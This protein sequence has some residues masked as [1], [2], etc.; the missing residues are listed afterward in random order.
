MLLAKNLLARVAKW[1]FKRSEQ[2]GWRVRMKGLL[3]PSSEAKQVIIRTFTVSHD[4]V[5]EGAKLTLSL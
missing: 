4:T 5:L 1:Q 3:H 2:E